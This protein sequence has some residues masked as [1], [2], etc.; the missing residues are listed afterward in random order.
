MNITKPLEDA[1]YAYYIKYISLRKQEI[2]ERDLPDRPTWEELTSKKYANAVLHDML[3][4]TLYK[5]M[6]KGREWE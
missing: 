2:L 6:T 4:E 3:Y 5:G 1:F